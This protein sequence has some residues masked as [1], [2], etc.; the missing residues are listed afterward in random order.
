MSSQTTQ[1]NDAT[2]RAGAVARFLVAFILFVGGFVAFGWAFTVDSG[3]A[4]IFSAGL[5]LVTI[6]FWIP[7][8]GRDR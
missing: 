1:R 4:L 3:Q 6:G 8:A 2:E 7:V 5:V